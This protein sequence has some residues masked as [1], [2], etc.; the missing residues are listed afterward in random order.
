MIISLNDD[1]HAFKKKEDK[2]KMSYIDKYFSKNAKKSIN[3]NSFS[4]NNMQ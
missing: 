2:Q 3:T 1:V 4:W